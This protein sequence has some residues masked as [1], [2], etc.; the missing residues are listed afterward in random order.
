MTVTISPVKVAKMANRSSGMTPDRALMSGVGRAGNQP[1]FH[2]S[3][4]EIRKAPVVG[5]VLVAGPARLGRGGLG[6]FALAIAPGLDAIPTNP[7]HRPRNFQTVFRVGS[8]SIPPSIRVN[9]RVCS[10]LG[11]RMQLEQYLLSPLVRQIR[12]HPARL[13][14]NP[15][16]PSCSMTSMLTWR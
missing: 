3:P 5:L 11:R 10:S 15:L 16:F 8:Q 7:P 12:Q 2:R 6:S 13:A 4:S 14:K 9:R 1:G